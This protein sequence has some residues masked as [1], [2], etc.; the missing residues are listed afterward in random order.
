LEAGFIATEQGG[1]KTMKSVLSLGCAL[2]LLFGSLLTIVPNNANAD[3][4]YAENFEDGTA[5]GIVRYYPWDWAVVTEGSNHFFQYY[6]PYGGNPNS[7]IWLSQTFSDGINIGF[8]S[9]HGSGGGEVWDVSLAGTGWTLGLWADTIDH[10]GK[11]G[12]SIGNNW[13]YLGASPLQRNQWYDFD[14]TLV[15]GVVTLYIDGV[16]F[17][18]VNIGNY[19]AAADLKNFQIQWGTW[20]NR[21]LDNIEVSTAPVPE[22]ATMLLLGSGLAGLAGF[23]KRFRKA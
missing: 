12:W 23:R 13:G 11:I 3:I 19:I 1:K 8:M 6:Y 5:D 15:G 16:Y 9:R 10:P 7:P 4:L 21:D 18:E 17:N 20:G 22:P 2:L 14:I